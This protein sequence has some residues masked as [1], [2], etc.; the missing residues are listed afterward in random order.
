MRSIKTRWFVFHPH[1]YGIA[2]LMRVGFRWRGH[3]L[4]LHHFRP[5]SET[6]FHDHPWPFRTVVLWG[7]Y[8]DE[9]LDPVTG[10]VVVDRLRIGSVR[11]RPAKHCHRT[12]ARRHTLTLMRAWPKERN[13]CEG[14]PGAWSCDGDSEDF[15]ATRG[16]RK[17][18]A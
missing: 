12:H 2:T 5:H 13:W 16:M 15:D 7:G 9:S 8:T 6:K 18:R 1:S 10:D 17:A 11:Y 14:E 4:L 3:Q